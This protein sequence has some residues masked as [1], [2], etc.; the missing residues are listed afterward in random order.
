MATEIVFEKKEDSK[1]LIN[2]MEKGDC[3]VYEGELFMRVDDN[4]LNVTN[5]SRGMRSA[6]T[7]D[8]KA[9]I[10]DIKIIVKG[11]K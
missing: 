3:F 4:N 7:D 11:E 1:V 5:L 8:F 6:F 9:I 10:V 2:K